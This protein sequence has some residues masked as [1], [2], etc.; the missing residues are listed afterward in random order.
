MKT[1]YTITTPFGTV[2]RTSAKNYT[3]VV[4]C[5]PATKPNHYQNDEVCIFNLTKIK[6]GTGYLVGFA[7]SH[8]LAKKLTRSWRIQSSEK[9][10]ILEITNEMKS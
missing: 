4:V 1:I 2:T 7:S 3:H 5:A 8:D 10:L 6:D 9:I